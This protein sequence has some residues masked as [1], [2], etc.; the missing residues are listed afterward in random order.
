MCCLPLNQIEERNREVRALFMAQWNL[1]GKDGHAEAHA[2]YAAA[3]REYRKVLME[4]INELQGS[5]QTDD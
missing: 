3:E 2:V 1:I 5:V 4:A